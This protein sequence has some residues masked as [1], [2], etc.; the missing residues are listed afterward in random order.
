MKKFILL[1]IFILFLGGISALCEEGQID[2]NSA[3]KEKL[4]DLN[5]IG[6]VYAGRIIELRPFSSVDE[7]VNV[8]GIA[9]KTLAKIKI[10]GLVCV[11]EENVEEK[12]GQSEEE[13]KEDTPKDKQI[14]ENTENIDFPNNQIQE[15]SDSY[16]TPIQSEVIKLDTKDIKSE[17]N[18]KEKD[19]SVYAKYGFVIFCVLLGTLFILKKDKHKKNEFGR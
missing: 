15:L 14:I 11:S 18:T 7:L 10:Q 17:N 5:G 3:T 9:D 6:P 19:K 13:E 8:K 16:K 4:E 12:I 2:I 1:F